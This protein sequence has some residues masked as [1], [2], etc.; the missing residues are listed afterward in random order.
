MVAVNPH[1]KEGQNYRN[2]QQGQGSSQGALPSGGGVGGT[3][4]M[5]KGARCS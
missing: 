4:A 3:M 2:R 5:A 1:S